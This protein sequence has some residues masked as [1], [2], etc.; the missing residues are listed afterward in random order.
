MNTI[1]IGDEMRVIDRVDVYL[2]G[3]ESG[4]VS[5]I[6]EKSRAFKLSD[7]IHE[8]VATQNIIKIASGASSYSSIPL[9]ARQVIPIPAKS[10]NPADRAKKIEYAAAVYSASIFGEI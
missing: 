4:N 10:R 3:G 2:G 9:S 5:E 6:L 7:K 1:K 8:R